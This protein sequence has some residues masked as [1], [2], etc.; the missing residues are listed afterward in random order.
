M[1]TPMSSR[2]FDSDPVA[3]PEPAHAIREEQLDDQ[4]KGYKSRLAPE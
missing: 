1:V 4:D 2:T 3:F